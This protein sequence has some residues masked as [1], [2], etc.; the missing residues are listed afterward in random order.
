M[1]SKARIA[2]HIAPI[3][4]KQIQV[5]NIETYIEP[6]VGGANMIEHIV[7]KN[8]YGYDNNRYLISFLK[9]LQSGWN[10]LIE[11]EMSK[12]LYSHVKNNINDYPEQIVALCGLCATYNAKWFGGYAGTVHTK[13]GTERDYYNEAVRN[14]LKQIPNLLDV[15]FDCRD[16]KALGNE[17]SNT[18]IYCD[19]PYFNTTKYAKDFDHD[20]FWQWV[21]DRSKTNIVF[22]SEYTA[23]DEFECVWEGTV[24]TTLDKNSRISAVEKLFIAA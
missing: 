5:N 19:P 1:G 12:D 16:Y 22:V 10:P 3:I 17:I 9:A 24:T 20:K 8:K 18:V 2:T 21:I 11:I 6:F 4:N 15:Y 7:C 23:P 13:I 14:V